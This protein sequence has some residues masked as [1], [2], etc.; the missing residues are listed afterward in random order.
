[1]RSST[2]AAGFSLLLAGLAIA[3]DV[4]DL[5]T[6]TFRDFVSEHDLVLAEF[7]APWCGHCKA[8]APE[9]EEAATALKE[10]DIPLAKIDCTVEAELCKDY[11][12]E[13]Y[14]TVKVFRGLDN[15]K[16]YTGAR[17]APAIISYMTK[18][19]LPAVSL[20]TDEN[21]NEFKTADKIV[22]VAFIS[23]DDKAA[24]QSFTAAADKLR[25]EYVFGASNDEALAKAEGVKQPA[26]IVYKDFDEGKTPFEDDFTTESIAKFVKTAS[27]PLVG[28]VSPETYAGYISS[29]IPLAY[30]FA[31][32]AEERAELAKT[33]RPVAEKHRGKL[34]IA[35]IDAKAFGAHASN[36]NLPTD[37]FPAFA[38]QETVKNEK[39][40]F[41][42][43][44]ITEKSIDTFVQDFVDGKLS[45][46]IKSEPI[47]E[48]QDGP[49]TV[50]VA[51]TYEEIVLNNDKD[52]LIE[53]YAPWCG[54]C[55]ALA[56]KYEELGALF[57]KSPDFEAKVTIAKIDANAN[58]VPDEIRGFPTIKLFPAGDKSNPVEYSGPRTVEDLANFV[59]DNGK[60][61]IDALAFEDEQQDEVE[62]PSSAEPELHETASVAPESDSATASETA[63]AT[64]ATEATEEATEE[65]KTAEAAEATEGIADKSWACTLRGRI[66]QLSQDTTQIRYRTIWPSR[67]ESPLTPPSSATSS[68]DEAEEDS[69]EVLTHYLNLDPDLSLL[70]SQWSAS[71]ANF[72]RKAA[73]FTGV[74]ILRQDAWEALVGFICSSNNN[75]KR[76]SQMMDKLCRHYGKYIATLDGQE[77]HDFPPPS[78]LTGDAVEAH[79]REL[80]FG[81]RAKYIVHTARAVCAKGSGWL[82][83][84]QNPESQGFGQSASTGEEWRVEGR[85][86]YRRAH[87]ELL[88]LMGVGAKVAD[89]VCLM[90]L[91]WGEAVPVDT[92]VWQIAQRDYRFGKGKHA[93]LTKATYDA[94]AT[95]FR[96]LWGQ[97][98]GWAH[99]VLFAA[100]L[101]QFADRLAVKAEPKLED[102]QAGEICTA[103]NSPR[104][105]TPPAGLEPTAAQM[106]LPD[107]I[108]PLAASTGLLSALLLLAAPLPTT[109]Q[110]LPPQYLD[111]SSLGQ[112]ALTGDF[113]AISVVTDAGKPQGPSNNGS[114]A[115]LSHLNDGTYDS[116]A[117]T[118]ATIQAMCPW[119]RKDGAHEGIVVAGNFT[120]IGGVPARSVAL[121]N[122]TL[123]TV[124]AL[125]GIEGNVF[126]LLCDNDTETVYVGGLFKA[127]NSSNAI[128]LNASGSWV[129]LPFA[130]FDAPVYSITKGSDGHVVFGGSFT[131]LGTGNETVETSNKT[132]TATQVINLL[133]AS[134]SAGSNTTSGGFITCPS[135]SSAASSNPFLLAD[136]SPGF[137]QADFG[138][139]FE[140]AK[141]RL[142]NT[143]QDGRGTKTWRYTAFPINGIMNFTYTDP[144]TGDEQ[145]CS[146]ECPL[147]QTTST[148]YQ[149]FYFVNTVGM[150]SFRID[151]SD[152]YGDGA[153]LAGIE[154][155]QDDIFA[156]AI[157]AFNQ[158]TCASETVSSVS[159]T[160]N[161]YTVPS[162]SSVADYLTVVVGPTTVDTDQIV[163]EPNVSEKGNYSV[164]V[165]TPGCIQDSSC[166]ARGSVNVTVSV[167]SEGAEPSTTLVSQTNNFDKYDQVYQG[168]VDP[169][170]SSFRP[171]VTIAA[172]GLDSAQLIV[173][174]RV[175]FVK[176][177]STGGLNGL[178]DYDP[179]D[180]VSSLDFSTSVIDSSG[181]KLSAKAKVLALS[182]NDDI[183]YA[184]GSFSDK[185]HTNV[186]A[187]SGNQVLTLPGGGLNAPVS[188]LYSQG[189]FLYVAG[190]FN[191]TQD[192]SASGLRN[193]AAYQYS[194]QSWVA[195]GAGL[196][197]PVDQVVPLLIN[198]SS[199]NQEMMIAFSGGF[200]SILATSGDDAVK[201]KGLAVWTP[202]ASN[203]LVN[204]DISQQLLS[205]HVIAGTTTPNGTWLGAGT[206]SSLGMAI[207]GAAGMQSD[208]DGNIRL[209]P[210]GLD[211]GSST[212]QSSGQ[213]KRALTT[214]SQSNVSGVTTGAYYSEN[215]QNI[216]IFGGHFSA[217]G[218]DGSTI[219]NLLFLNSTDNDTMTGLP[220]GIDTNSTFYSLTLQSN[221]LL[222]GGNVTGNI[223]GVAVG[224]LVF[225]DMQT[226]DFRQIQPAPLVGPDVVVNAISILSGTSGVYV[227]GAFQ[228]TSQGLSCPCVCM[229][230]LDTSQWNAVGSGLDGTVVSL[231][232]TSDSQ[233][234]AAG[235]LTLNGNV[236]T[237]AQYNPKQ[238]T[239]E[240]V[241]DGEIPGP[242]TAFWPGTTDGSQIW[243]AGTAQNGST[244]L[245]EI[246]DNTLRPVLD[247]FSTGTIIRGL[248]QVGLTKSHSSTPSLGNN[249]ALLVTGQL[250]LTQ[251]GLA[252]A[253][254]F[255]GTTA[256]PLISASKKD[257]SAGSLSRMV[258]SNMNNASS[259]RH[260]HS[261]GI[262]VLVS[263]CAALGT[264]FLII[265][266]GIILNRLQRRRAGYSAIASVPYADKPS[267][268]ARV[269][270]ERLFGNLGQGTGPHV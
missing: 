63:E 157:E 95:H 30:I 57:T 44:E 109:S 62:Q 68:D 206:L 39:Y 152:W 66:V 138:F 211:I 246:A 176:I 96:K 233:L 104:C 209:S 94:I 81:Y 179:S 174:S 210:I 219:N 198:T 31:E 19:Q 11:G 53:F 143:N 70:Y 136:E 266:I 41:E 40:P 82:D 253:A 121:Y 89:C 167:S 2:A 110:Q 145:S 10:K 123:G 149:D 213:Q 103:V 42:G 18:Q 208:S 147:A 125:P 169:V 65:A 32:T 16:P 45:P 228:A 61:K 48:T 26:V 113:D 197:G 80:G 83:S 6:D 91:G 50:V 158:P 60:W 254:L 148:G 131:G 15:I 204:T 128:A 163:F 5:K 268:I 151:I 137:W 252:S 99:S 64:E 23:A 200:K 13:G 134:L 47:P 248:Q 196:D 170:S 77:Y 207:N 58:D 265:L 37:S 74:R 251:Y 269:P 130:G 106:R 199:T 36:L 116:L 76:I 201:V 118:D 190:S 237:L 178:F 162:R 177:A 221:I 264:I 85:A 175:Q 126:A 255:N 238:Q 55:K 88:A 182:T 7:F 124:V 46:S 22:V 102:L 260:H 164:I 92:H 129:D 215:N 120:S 69:R 187:F 189:D 8:L 244:Y 84:L 1:M 127:L 56:P 161:W 267:N 224:G 97:E 232:W 49:V 100:D 262:V 115:V 28:E 132:S 202:S 173:A 154:L 159:T 192:G 17:K 185:T 155:F 98:A 43:G 230:D 12:V 226:A 235:N 186:L 141:L 25:D 153:G 119:V 135:N 258:S 78:A 172:S 14:P 93:S 250:N 181:N 51:H 259:P 216:S 133:T 195:L 214:T 52:V 59:R 180:P 234:L 227:G 249:E 236:T 54:H 117:Y 3:S 203:W 166:S 140:P 241:S 229:Y 72:K 105:P 34:N 212:E 101:S 168:H 112:V 270:P 122:S 150:N 144:D 225:Y 256:V 38:I 194:T 218:S 146:A 21:L 87:D 27:T 108:Q 242:I 107:R 222:A 243:V 193:V 29:G 160:G 86:A 35:V 184:A 165:Y 75:I 240:S 261:V 263:L 191:S 67:P 73:K 205:G 20:V 111:L 79:F 217:T 183:V 9:Y 220:E 71:D 139:G 239:W 24:N 142:W 257:G 33:L 245:M 156:Y 231:Y 247:T 4:H 171:Q 114:V 90:G 188:S 223:N